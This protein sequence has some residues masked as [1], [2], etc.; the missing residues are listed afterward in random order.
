M[1][2]NLL[3]PDFKRDLRWFAKFFPMYNGISLYDHKKVDAAFVLGA[4]LT[5]F[6]GVVGA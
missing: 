4:C 2:K 6:G 3:T 5:S 1:S